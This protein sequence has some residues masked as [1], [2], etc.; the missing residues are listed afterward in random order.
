VMNLSTIPSQSSL[1]VSPYPNQRRRGRRYQEANR[2]PQLFP[3]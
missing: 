1:N 2:R 3:K